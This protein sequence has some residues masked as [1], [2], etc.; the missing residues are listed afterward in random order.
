MFYD[1]HSNP[2]QNGMWRSQTC[3]LW[4]Y[5]LD[6]FVFHFFNTWCCSRNV[7]CC[8]CSEGC[9]LVCLFFFAV[10]CTL[11]SRRVAVLLSGGCSVLTLWWGLSGS[12][13]TGMVKHFKFRLV[14]SLG[15]GWVV[16]AIWTFTSCLLVYF[17]IIA[18]L[19]LSNFTPN[20]I[21]FTLDFCVVVEGGFV[22]CAILLSGTIK[23]Y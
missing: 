23:L 20:G 18:S 11:V 8:W 10:L 17:E 4:F 14:I 2:L 12:L 3:S 13:L 9:P 7:Y 22:S 15:V 5:I 16:Y 1:V 21:S 19:S 6:V